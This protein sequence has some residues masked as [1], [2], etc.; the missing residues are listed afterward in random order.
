MIKNIHHPN[1]KAFKE[2]LVSARK[3][4]G[5]S[6]RELAEL[7]NEPHSIVVKIELGSRKLSL[8]EYPQYCKALKL[9]PAVGLEIL[10]IADD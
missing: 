8:F 10:T 4:Q 1:Y 3:E 5:L 6:V 9:D 2:W 7:I